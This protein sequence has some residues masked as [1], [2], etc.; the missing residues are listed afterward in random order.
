MNTEN[1]QVSDFINIKKGGSVNSNDFTTTLMMGKVVKISE[2]MII[3]H[4]ML[5]SGDYIAAKIDTDDDRGYFIT[6]EREVESIEDIYV[7]FTG[8]DNNLGFGIFD[9]E[10]DVIDLSDDDKLI[11][12][13]NY[14]NNNKQYKSLE[15]LESINYEIEKYLENEK[16]GLDDVKNSK[17]KDYFKIC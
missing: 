10:K 13:E 6:Q 8:E 4:S 9:N 17:M 7:Q 11:E 14:N 12:E 5:K 2:P 1:F 3:V 15:S 16:S